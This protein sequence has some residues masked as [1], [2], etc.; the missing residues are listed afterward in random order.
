MDFI[1]RQDAPRR[2][3]TRKWSE[4]GPGQLAAGARAHV[5]TW[6]LGGTG[7]AEGTS[8]GPM[9]CGQEPG[10]LDSIQLHPS[11]NKMAAPAVPPSVVC[12]A[13]HAIPLCFCECGSHGASR[14]Q[15]ARGRGCLSL[16]LPHLPISCPD[17]TVKTTGQGTCENVSLRQRLP[18]GTISH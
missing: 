2:L 9:E 13:E 6:P 17:R 4:V 5:G 16:T 10:F 8:P 11:G 1:H 3:E 12:R 7:L 14:C 18:Q 15:E